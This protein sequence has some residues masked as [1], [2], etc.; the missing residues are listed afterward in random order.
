M[1]DNNKVIHYQSI[2]FQIFKFSGSVRA[3]IAQSYLSEHNRLRVSLANMLLFI[4]GTIL[5]I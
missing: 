1:Y 3:N 2:N 4:L 5:V